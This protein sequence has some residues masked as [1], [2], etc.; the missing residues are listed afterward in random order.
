MATTNMQFGQSAINVVLNEGQLPAK[1]ST[2]ASGNTVLVGANGSASFNDAGLRGASPS[3]TAAINYAAIQAA[4]NASGDV[5]ISTP[6]VIEVSRTLV[7]SSGTR[8]KIGKNTLLKLAAASSCQVIRNRGSQ[9]STNIASGKVAIA[10][11]VVTITEA[12]HPYAVGD[13]VFIENVLTNT[14]L[15]GFKTITAVVAGVNWSFAGTGVVPTNTAKQ[16]IFVSFANQLAGSN[17]VRASNVVTVTETGHKRS[18]GDHV[19]VANLGG[20]NSFNGAFKILAATPGVSWTYANTGADETATDTAQLLGDYNIELDVRLD[21]NKANQTYDSSAYAISLGNISRSQF[22]IDEAHNDAIRVINF[23]NASNIHVPYGNFVDCRVGMQCD[24]ACDEISI[25]T[26]VGSN[27]ID[28]VLAWG[29]TQYGSASYGDTASPCNMYSMGSLHVGA[30]LGDSATGMFKVYC[31]TG[32]NLG[33]VRVDA[34]HGRGTCTFGDNTSGAA[35]GNIDS[36]SIGVFDCAASGSTSQLTIPASAW[37]KIRDLNIDEFHSSWTAGVNTGY[38]I[39]TGAP[40]DRMRIGRLIGVVGEFPTTSHIISGTSSVITELVID[41]S[42][43]PAGAAGSAVSI[44]NS[45]TITTLKFNNCE[46]VGASAYQGEMVKLGAGSTLSNLFLNNHT[47]N[48]GAAA[49][50]GAN[51]SPAINIFIDGITY[52][53]NPSVLISDNGGNQPIT[54]YANNANMVST[55]TGSVLKFTGTGLKRFS[56]TGVA[57]TLAKFVDISSANPSI[58]INCRDVK[59]DLG[60]NAATPPAT[61][62]PLAGDQIFNSNATGTGVYGRTN[63][64]AWQLLY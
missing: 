57:H 40:I 51:T 22:K 16:R 50:L 27:M 64:G 17:F 21:S 55:A 49:F 39:N 1:I 10:G 19:Y 48:G 59:L 6:G 30:L 42:T 3:A 2:D 13:V 58:S 32:Y 61:L 31:H 43:I 9:S 18:K 12:G 26:L 56:G 23:Y 33:K 29:I 38:G 44:Q 41:N 24:S 62:I 25:G 14:T 34:I 52:K 4:L 36:I 28:D 20:T 5:S 46:F 15:N 54:V 53:N 8:L 11:G 35:G 45:S 47:Q 63:A 60:A 7:V 37:T